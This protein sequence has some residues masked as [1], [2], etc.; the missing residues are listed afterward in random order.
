MDTKKPSVFNGAVLLNSIWNGVLIY[1]G[2][3]IF[4]ISLSTKK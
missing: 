2:L 1:T 3:K 4:K